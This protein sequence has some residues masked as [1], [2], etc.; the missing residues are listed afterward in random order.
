MKVLGRVIKRKD[1][2]S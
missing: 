2:E 1:S